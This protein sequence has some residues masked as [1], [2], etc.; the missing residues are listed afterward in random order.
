MEG[1]CPFFTSSFLQ[2][3]LWYLF[4]FSVLLVWVHPGLPGVSPVLALKVPW[5]EKSLSS[6]QFSSVAQSC[7]T[8]CEIWGL[9]NPSVAAK[10]GTFDLPSF[11][12][13][14]LLKLSLRPGVGTGSLFGRCSQGAEVRGLG[15]H[16]KK[17]RRE[18]RGGKKHNTERKQ[19]KSMKSQTKACK[20]C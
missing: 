17:G 6:V 15:E 20:A 7:L 12:L 1:H 8:L 19:G 4:L 18:R 2:L 10:L 13:V 14:S 3:F 5:S 11:W 16:G 9:R